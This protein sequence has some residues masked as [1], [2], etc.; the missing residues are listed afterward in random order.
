MEYSRS[1]IR[2]IIGNVEKAQTVSLRGVPGADV[3]WGARRGNLDLR[4]PDAGAQKA[5]SSSN[6]SC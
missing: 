3:G 4:S 5:S 6:D 1:L 2:D